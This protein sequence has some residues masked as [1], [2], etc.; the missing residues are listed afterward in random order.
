MPT[1]SGT[2]KV[3]LTAQDPEL[4]GAAS[5]FA[6]AENWQGDLVGSGRGVMLSGGDP[7]SGAAGYVAIETVHGHLGERAGSFAFVQLA[8]MAAGGRP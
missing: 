6:L 1:A 5:R 4:D 3:E 8:L 2:F 7:G